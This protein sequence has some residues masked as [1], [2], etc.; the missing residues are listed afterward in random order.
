MRKAGAHVRVAVSALSLSAA[1]FV[2]LTVHEGYT[3]RAVIPT[4]G[5]VPTL[6]FGSTVHEDGRRVQMG[7]RTD[8]VNALKKAQAHISKEEQRFR[9]SLPGAHLTQA[10]Y[11]VYMDW[12]YQY[13]SGAWGRSAM[14]REILAGNHRAA[15]DALL[16]YRF[17]DGYDCSTPG[18]RRCMGVWTRQ[19][20]RHKACLEAQ[21]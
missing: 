15:C 16:R 10:E 12:V 8:P 13:G 3:D 6:G 11:D 18:N 7:E 5:D 9:A 19:Q 14:R 21:L 4:K 1:A 20:A 17:V 2:G